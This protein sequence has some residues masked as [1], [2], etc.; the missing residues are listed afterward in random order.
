LAAAVAT[1]DNFLAELPS[2]DSVGLVAFSS[3]AFVAVPPTQDRNLVRQELV[4]LRIGDG[5]A[6]GDAVLLAAGLGQKQRAA[7]GVVPPTSVLLISDGTPDGGRVPA[8]AAARRAKALGVPVSTGLVVTAKLTGG[9]T[10]QIRVPASPGTLQVIARTS[11]GSFYPARTP[12]ALAGVYRKLATRLGH[13]TEDRQITD[14]FAGGAAVLLLVG[15]SLSF[16]WF[17]RL[18]P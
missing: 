7:D 17:R 5:T 9:Y 11:G 15:S 18:V 10:E 12:Q 6:I 1:A 8:S 13:T 4:Q 14:V 16:A 3:S 2:R